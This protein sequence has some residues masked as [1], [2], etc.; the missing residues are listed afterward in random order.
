MDENK[1]RMIQQESIRHKTGAALP[2][3]NEWAVKLR[4]LEPTRTNFSEVEYDELLYLE[5]GMSNIPKDMFHEYKTLFGMRLTEA[6]HW[7]GMGGPYIGVAALVNVENKFDMKIL[8]SI[9]GTQLGYVFAPPYKATI[10]QFRKGF[11]NKS[12]VQKIISP[13]QNQEEGF[14]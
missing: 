10:K 11:E 4:L 5:A 9:D 12:G 8:N 1:F 3:D 13:Q 2:P 6:A 7:L 14:E